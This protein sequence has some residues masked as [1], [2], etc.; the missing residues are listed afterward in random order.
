MSDFDLSGYLSQFD[1]S[2]ADP[3]IQDALSPVRIAQR[4]QEVARAAQAKSEALDNIAARR[5]REVNPFIASFG[6][7]SGRLVENFGILTGGYDGAMRRFGSEVADY[8]EQRKPNTLVDKELKRSQTV[9]AQNGELAQG[10]TAFWETVKDPE[11]LLSLVMESVPSLA[12][13]GVA[14]RAVGAGARALGAGQQVANRAATAAALGEAGAEQGAS[15]AGETYDELLKLGDDLWDQN[16]DFQAMAGIVGREEAKRRI[17]NKLATRAGM[18]AGAVS[19][20]SQKL[21]GGSRLERSLAGTSNRTG[22][23][24]GNV[25]MGLAG[26]ATQ[27]AIEEGSGVIAGNVAKQQVDAAQ[28]TFTGVGEAAG[29]GAAAGGVLGGVTGAADTRISDFKERDEQKAQDKI[30]TKAAVKEAEKTGKVDELLANNKNYEAAQVALNRINDQ[31]LTEDERNAA[32]ADLAKATTALDEQIK[33]LESDSETTTQDTATEEKLAAH[34]AK[35]ERAKEAISDFKKLQD[36]AK[37]DSEAVAGYQKNIDQVEAWLRVSDVKRQNIVDNAATTFEQDKRDRAKEIETLKGQQ[38]KLDEMT[39]AKR[40]DAR[41]P[42]EEVE[43]LVKQVESEEDTP[44]RAEAVDKVIKMG[45]R[46][47]GAFDEEDVGRLAQ[48]PNIPEDA[49]EMFQAF[50]DAQAAANSR[51]TIGD[52]KQQVEGGREGFQGL[53]SYIGRVGHFLKIGDTQGA[54]DDLN[55]L[56]SFAVKH[57]AKLAKLKEARAQAQQSGRT[58]Y[59]ERQEDGSFVIRSQKPWSNEAARQTNGGFYI[60]PTDKGLAAGSRLIEAVELEVTALNQTGKQLAAAVRLARKEGG[61]AAATQSGPS[62]QNTTTQNEEGRIRRPTRNEKS[63]VGLDENNPP[64]ISEED[65]ADLPPD[66]Q[67]ETVSAGDTQN[68][69]Q[70][71]QTVSQ[72][73]TQEADA[74]PAAQAEPEQA[75]EA[76]ETETP[77]TPVAQDATQQTD[78]FEDV[79]PSDEPSTVSR[80]NELGAQLQGVNREIKQLDKD[81]GR[82]SR[83]IRSLTPTG[84][85]GPA[86]ELDLI[87]AIKKLGGINRKFASQFSDYFKSNAKLFRLREDLGT[88]VDDMATLLNG[89]E[90]VPYFGEAV[91]GNELLQYIDQALDGALIYSPNSSTAAERQGLQDQLDQLQQLE[92]EAK[93]RKAELERELDELRPAQEGSTADTTSEGQSETAADILAA[94]DEAEKQDKGLEQEDLTAG[95]EQSADYVTL[96]EWNNRKDKPINWFTRYFTQKVQSETSQRPLAVANFMSEFIANAKAGFLKPFLSQ[97]LQQ[98]EREGISHFKEF[99][100]TTVPGDGDSKTPLMDL[101]KLSKEQLK[102]AKDYPHRNLLAQIRN[103]DDSVNEN[104]ATAIAYAAYHWLASAPP[105]KP[106]SDKEIKNMLG[107]AEEDQ[108]DYR[109]LNSLRFVGV[110]RATAERAL[111]RVAAQALGYVPIQGAPSNLQTLF[112]TALGQQAMAVLMGSKLLTENSQ[113]ILWDADSA[114]V[115]MNFVKVAKGRAEGYVKT[116]GE[117]YRESDMVIDD[118]FRGSRDFET[119]WPQEEPEFKQRKINNSNRAIPEEQRDLLNDSVQ[120]LYTMEPEMAE[121]REV[122]TEDE[123]LLMAG[124]DA[125]DEN[126]R[127]HE[128][129]KGERESRFIGMKRELTFLNEW[130]AKIGEKLFALAPSVKKQQRVHF[131]STVIDPQGNKSQRFDMSLEAWKTRLTPGKKDKVKLFRVAVAQGLGIKVDKMRPE[132]ALKELDEILAIEE[133]PITK[134]IEAARGN[135]EENKEDFIAG[136]L[137]AGEDMHSFR[138]IIEMARFLNHDFNDPASGAFETRLSIEVDGVA[139]G[140]ALSQIALGAAEKSLGAIYGFFTPKDDVTNFPHFAESGSPDIYE[141]LALAV[142]RR[143][144]DKSY[145]FGIPDDANMEKK[146]PGTTRKI[147]KDTVIPS[148]FGAGLNKVIGNMAHGVIGRFYLSIEEIANSGDTEA[149]QVAR[150]NAEIKKFNDAAREGNKGRN[151]FKPVRTS[152]EGLKQSLT[153]DQ[154]KWFVRAYQNTVGEQINEAMDEELGPFLKNRT[155]LNQMANSIWARYNAAFQYFYQQRMNELIANQ[156]LPL[157]NQGNPLQ[158][159]SATDMDRIRKQVFK[160]GLVPIV[161]TAMSSGGTI[162]AGLD[163]E[164]VL[165]KAAQGEVAYQVTQAFGVPVPIIQLN[166]ETK[167]SNSRTTYAQKRSTAEPGVAILPMLV[168]AMDSAIA[169]RTYGNVPALNVHDA[170]FMGLDQVNEGATLLNE[171]TF[172]ALANYSIPLSV[173]NALE[174]TYAQQAAVAEFPGLTEALAAATISEMQEVAEGEFAMVDIPVDEIREGLRDS[175]LEMEQKKLQ[176]LQEIQY[177]N[178]YG[179]TDGVYE[180]TDKDIEAVNERLAEVETLIANRTPSAENLTEEGAEQDDGAGSTSGG[181]PAPPSADENP[182]GFTMPTEDY[183]E[184]KVGRPLIET[185]EA[186]RKLF[187]AKPNRTVKEILWTLRTEIKNSGYPKNREEFLLALVNRI[188]NAA[189]VKDLPIYVV[190][191]KFEKNIPGRGEFT[192][193]PDGTAAGIELALV[194]SDLENSGLNLETVIHELVHAATARLINAP[195]AELT[196]DQKKARNNLKEVYKVARAYVYAD[197]ELKAEWAYAVKDLDEMV[198]YGMTNLEFQQEVLMKAQVS[199]SVIS[200]VNTAFKTKK[201]LLNAFGQ[202]VRSITDLVF[203]RGNRQSQYTG[204][205]QLMV[206]APILFSKSSKLY[207]AGRQ[208]NHTKLSMGMSASNSMT[209]TSEQI[210]DALERNPHTTSVSNPEHRKRLKDVLKNVVDV[211]YE[212][213]SALREKAHVTAPVTADDVFLQAKM[214][215]QT[216]FAGEAEINLTTNDQEAF[217]MTSVELAVSEAMQRNPSLRREMERLYREARAFVKPADLPKGEY[218]FLFK[219]TEKTYLSRFAAAAIAYEP[220][221][222]KLSQGQ[223]Q[224]PNLNAPTSLAARVANLFARLLAWLD[225]WNTKVNTGDRYDVAVGSLA[226]RMASVEVR[227]QR[228]LERRKTGLGAVSARIDDQLEFGSNKIRNALKSIGEQDI[229]RNSP[230]AAARVGG[231]ASGQY[232][233]NRQKTL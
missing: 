80:R 198:A 134:A 26:E 4:Q 139:N 83:R 156:Q 159:L 231:A 124:F 92:S 227:T 13:G 41:P 200:D 164:K 91:T 18:A 125:I 75:G 182:S 27:E 178:Q 90:G 147:F 116:V 221:V 118:L 201:G 74:T 163:I 24:I 115:S 222:T 131:Q 208:G 176:F 49:R 168:H 103:E 217:V 53:S 38:I 84:L 104:V 42:V 25:A 86:S 143:A 31:E 52:V 82:I 195:E 94:L 111:G 37:G 137:K 79:E 149:N 233:V 144:P 101:L 204:M 180:V 40:E 173:N 205:Y 59:L 99:W 206:N 112:E 33:K 183:W 187:A 191:K 214:S 146:V 226:N 152:N 43:S 207:E 211:M 109:V 170:L 179:W 140:A 51:Y 129:L 218:E 150:M 66:Q 85:K 35:V 190:E 199:E 20:A 230:L 185:N 54:I 158:E 229:V 223:V 148:T 194:S 88:S 154:A 57:E 172:S 224:G 117:I 93:F 186:L 105:N 138:A 96:D 6:L 39:Q 151:F 9:A 167:A 161:H 63:A 135:L 202:F 114:P 23:V 47:P 155:I 78:I 16:A 120:N 136:V 7:G 181:Q 213:D 171:N 55:K 12:A 193:N 166:G 36:A 108:V 87:S 232:S 60:A 122:F 126:D 46:D 67:D 169:S 10:A 8:W 64:P 212:G 29:L 30:E 44:E 189:D 76:V 196:A 165:F 70:D 61:A 15:V 100:E 5:D 160:L 95:E 2:A 72:P 130:R 210:F 56:K 62:Q 68:V 128:A 220:L 107:V 184:G 58:R 141:R 215:G 162:N 145:W 197:A 175:A 219:G 121:A 45:M 50:T 188:G 73:E 192:L 113:D 157:D 77:N 123:L 106:N 65:L 216:P 97:Q 81:A 225:S 209:Y 142:H 11:M 153:D 174:G 98:N 34:D 132:E 28:G 21:P 17:A 1:P 48:N 14:G 119:N 32:E 71:T 3:N 22:N 102:T 110:R 89:T 127:E 19:L 203:G 69:S 177:V 133:H 228:N